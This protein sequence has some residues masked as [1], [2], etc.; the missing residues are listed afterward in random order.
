VLSAGSISF[1]LLTSIFA[2]LIYFNL[3]GGRIKSAGGAAF[4]GFGVLLLVLGIFIRPL[5]YLGVAY[6]LILFALSRLGGRIWDTKVGLRL[7]VVGAL[8]FGLSMLDPNFF[9]IAA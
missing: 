5:L 1:V 9:L 4:V 3:L 6:F 8:A 7:F 2:L